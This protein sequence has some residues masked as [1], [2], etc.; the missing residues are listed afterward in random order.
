[1]PHYVIRVARSAGLAALFVMAAGLG[2]LSGVLFAYGGDLPQI[3]AL[4]QYAPSTITRVYA[5]HGEVIGEFATQR[6]VVIGYND[7]APRLRQ[8]IIAVE[9]D[10]FE[11]HVGVSVSSIAVR[12]VHDVLE[13]ARDVL[14]GRASRPAGASTLTQQLARNLFAQ[15]IG[16][17]AGDVSLERKVKEALVAIRIEKRYTKAEILALYC[18]QMYLGG[19]A[20]GVEAASRLYFDKHAR[21]STWRKRHTD[22]RDLP[23]AG[24]AS[25]SVNMKMGAASG[26]TTCSA[27][28]RNGISQADRRG[29]REGPIVVAQHAGAGTSLAPY[30]VEEVRI[31]STAGAKQLYERPRGADLARR[32]SPAG[33]QRR[34]S[35]AACASSTSG[36]GF[37]RPE[38]NIL[39]EGLVL[40]RFADNRWNRPIGPGDVVPAVVTAIG[41]CAVRPGRA[42]GSE[43]HRPASACS[44]R[45]TGPDWA[46]PC[47]PRPE[48]HRLDPPVIG[49]SLAQAR[50]PRGGADCEDRRR[51]RLGDCDA[52]S[53]TP[54]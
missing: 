3:S 26:G 8:A 39:S 20:Y 33:G 27:W 41:G 5:S 36:E 51:R 34:A 31:S 40:E 6:R 49:C 54:G 11:R 50:R 15:Q 22:R 38:R 32:R 7:I 24:A 9:D 30:F 25:P 43:P 42:R 46:A 45:R 23:A 1:V 44:G 29:P 21:T 13:K 19:G 37:R 10:S 35:N 48:R 16:F 4:D 17:R 52:R 18:N 28:P 2:A 53:A 47:R 14:T 12:L